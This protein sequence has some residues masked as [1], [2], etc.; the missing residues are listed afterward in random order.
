MNLDATVAFRRLHLVDGQAKWGQ[1]ALSA[2]N[3]VRSM[4]NQQMGI[5]CTG[6]DGNCERSCSRIP[7]DVQS[8]TI[9]ATEGFIGESFPFYG[10]MVGYVES[11][12]LFAPSFGCDYYGFDFSDFD[13]PDGVWFEGTAHMARAYK[14]LGM[15]PKAQF[16]LS[17]IE[18][19]LEEEGAHPEYPLW[20]GKGVPAACRDYL[21]TGFGGSYFNRPSVAPTAWYLMAAGNYNPLDVD[22][23]PPAD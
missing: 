14:A 18:R 6:T 9:L 1:A 13:E 23:E 21:T 16:F 11:E 20:L 3:F 4:V 10:R 15:N 19:A 5:L 12:M 2:W 17:E 7:E 8:W 22:W